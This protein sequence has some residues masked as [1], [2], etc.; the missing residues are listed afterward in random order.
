MTYFMKSKHGD[1]PL[2]PFPPS[3]NLPVW[4]LGGG[5]G[6]GVGTCAWPDLRLQRAFGTSGICTGL[7]L[8]QKFMTRAWANVGAIRE[9][10]VKE[11]KSLVKMNRWF[12]FINSLT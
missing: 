6:G 4:W 2:F 7:S 5:V 12:L 11:K 1:H 3:W 10:L 9:K 8:L